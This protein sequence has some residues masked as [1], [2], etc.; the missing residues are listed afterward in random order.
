MCAFITGEERIK[1]PVTLGKEK[2][3]RALKI[4]GSVF[5]R[6]AVFELSLPASLPAPISGRVDLSIKPC[7]EWPCWMEISFTPA[8]NASSIV[9]AALGT[10]IHTD[11][12]GTLCRLVVCSLELLVLPGVELVQSRLESSGVFPCRNRPKTF[13]FVEFCFPLLFCA[14]TSS[15]GLSF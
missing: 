13:H 9:F 15:T 10:V 5:T 2:F 3:C 8:R 6:R 11:R 14:Y 4:R 7:C 1:Q 12:L